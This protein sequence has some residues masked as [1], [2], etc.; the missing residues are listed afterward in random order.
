M[1]QVTETCTADQPMGYLLLM[2]TALVRSSGGTSLS[3]TNFEDSVKVEH[4]ANTYF[5]CKLPC[6]WRALPSWSG[7]FWYSIDVCSRSRYR[8]PACVGQVIVWCCAAGIG[9][10]WWNPCCDDTC[11]A[12]PSWLSLR[13]REVMF[14][15]SHVC[16]DSD[17]ILLIYALILCSTSNFW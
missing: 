10:I 13:L 9:M 4:L 6:F 15:G 3:T 8:A 16:Q 7:M 1:F 14:R 5:G 17:L 11:L 2:F 12:F